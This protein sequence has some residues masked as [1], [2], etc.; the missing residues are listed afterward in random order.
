M[1]TSDR[2]QY[3]QS[4][5]PLFLHSHGFAAQNLKVDQNGACIEQSQEPLPLLTLLSYIMFQEVKKKGYSIQ[6]T[7]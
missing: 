7:K 4:V 3:I 5:A 6:K 2:Q 1:N